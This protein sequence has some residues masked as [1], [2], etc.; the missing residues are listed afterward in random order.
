MAP[1]SRRRSRKPRSRVTPKLPPKMA[2]T[3]AALILR[4]PRSGRLEGCSRRRRSARANACLEMADPGI[5]P[6][7]DLRAGFRDAPAALLRTRRWVARSCN[8]LGSAAACAFLPS[9]DRSRRRAKVRRQSSRPLTVAPRRRP[10]TVRRSSR[11]PLP[12]LCW[13]EQSGDER[14]RRHPKPYRQHGDH[15]DV[16]ETFETE[17][18]VSRSNRLPRNQQ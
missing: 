7:A 9:R 17:G 1:R 4:S 13:A 3:S 14:H 8:P 10:G 11:Q 2:F 6:F 18:L 12:L 15:P 16:E 5:V